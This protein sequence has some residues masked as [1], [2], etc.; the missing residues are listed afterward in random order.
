MRRREVR[1]LSIENIAM[2]ESHSPLMSERMTRSRLF[3]L[4][5]V[6]ILRGI[7]AGMKIR[8]TQGTLS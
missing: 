1:E 8:Q 6:S 7:R 4:V 5:P 3:G 2:C